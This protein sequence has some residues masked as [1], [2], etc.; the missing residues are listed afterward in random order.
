M[1]VYEHRCPNCGADV[2]GTEVRPTTER[3]K[4]RLCHLSGLP[5]MVLVLG[6]TPLWWIFA[7]VPLNI[8][9]P[10]AW[11]SYQSGSP[12]VRRHLT[13]VLNFQVVW[14]VVMYLL[15][16]LWLVVGIALWPFVWFGGIIIVLFM[17]YDAGNGGDGKY[18]VRLP[19]FG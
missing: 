15:L 10:L 7:L 5:G 13:E 19:V 3:A 17:T 14:S 4:V 1:A 9:V 16:V 8:I 18:F 2:R 6:V 11:R 12:D